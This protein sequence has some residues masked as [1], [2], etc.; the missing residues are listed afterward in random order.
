MASRFDAFTRAGAGT[1]GPGRAAPRKGDDMLRTFAAGVAAVGLALAA[2]GP[3]AAQQPLTFKPIDTEKL[4]VKPTDQAAGLFSGVSRISS[5]I[6]AGSLDQ[7]G[8]VKTINNLFGRKTPTPGPQPG[9]SALPNPGLYPS[10][11]YPNS[12]QPAMPVYPR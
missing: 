6:I 7:N 10:T 4:I 12:F 8:F 5:R 9:F 3:A 11:R 2:A 1:G